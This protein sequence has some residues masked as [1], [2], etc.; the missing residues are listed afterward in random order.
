M[1]ADIPIKVRSKKETQNV[2]EGKIKH[3][4]N[5]LNND[6]VNTRNF[7]KGKSKLRNIIKKIIETEEPLPK[8]SFL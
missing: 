3:I 5:I 4:S 2:F 7:E 6:N 1:I 8:K